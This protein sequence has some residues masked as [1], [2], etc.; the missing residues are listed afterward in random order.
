MDLDPYLGRG[1][2]LAGY[3][4]L[5]VQAIVQAI[6]NERITTVAQFAWVIGIIA[7]PLWG[8]LVW[9]ALGHRTQELERELGLRRF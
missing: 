6:R 4:A 8:L 3:V 9:Y 7:A 1:L 5:L 2:V